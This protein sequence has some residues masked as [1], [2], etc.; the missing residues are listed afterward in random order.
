[1]PANGVMHF[2]GH[3]TYALSSPPN[4]RISFAQTAQAFLFGHLQFGEKW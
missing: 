4:C 2:D 3:V 1:M